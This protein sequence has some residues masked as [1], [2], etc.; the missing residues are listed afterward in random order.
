MPKKVE[1]KKGKK[2]PSTYVPK[3][4]SE[5]DKKKQIKSILDKKERPK[6]ESFKSKRSSW[7]EKFEDK[8]KTKI[9]DKK[10]IYKN[11]ISK[12]G[13]DQ[14]I[15]KGRGAY[16]S[17]GSRPN[18]TMFS[19]ANARLASVILGGGARK[20]DKKI[21]DKYKIKKDQKK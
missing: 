14:I 18:Q 15:A 5:K 9:T 11:I 17:A 2:V 19:W 12:E 1:I 4:L 3:G 7:V 21:W 16:Y 6:L 20:V 8:Y 10:F 13:V